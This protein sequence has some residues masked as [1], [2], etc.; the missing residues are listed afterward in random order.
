MQVDD[1]ALDIVLVDKSRLTKPTGGYRKKLPWKSAR[2]ME[3]LMEKENP[4]TLAEWNIGLSST[5]TVLLDL[6]HA[7]DPRDYLNGK[8]RWTFLSLTPVQ[9]S[10]LERDL[11]ATAASSDSRGT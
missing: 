9:A 3:I 6:C 10:Q 8:S 1:G 11:S 5:G 4:D 7:R 2:R